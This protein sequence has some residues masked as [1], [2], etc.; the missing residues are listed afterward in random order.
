VNVLTPPLSGDRVSVDWGFDTI[1]GIVDSVYSSGLGVRV[2]VTVP[3]LGPLGEELDH[4]T[5][6][7]PADSVHQL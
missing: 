7:L 2:T 3:V 1:E 4:M 5:V 6:T